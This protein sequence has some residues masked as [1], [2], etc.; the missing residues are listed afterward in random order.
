MS[1]ELDPK[2]AEGLVTTAVS[3][4]HSLP[5]EKIICTRRKL[6]QAVLAAVQEAYGLGFLYRRA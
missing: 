4:V 3:S 6:K 2:I 5:S 1:S